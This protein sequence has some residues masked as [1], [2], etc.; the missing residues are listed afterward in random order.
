VRAYHTL[1][2]EVI[3][4]LIHYVQVPKNTPPSLLKCLNVFAKFQLGCIGVML[5][6]LSYVLV[7]SVFWLSASVQQGDLLGPLLFSLVLWTSFTLQ[8]ST[9][10]FVVSGWWY[11]YWPTVFSNH[12]VDII[13]FQDGPAF[14]LY[15]NLAKCEI[16]WSSGDS[17]CLEFL[18]AVHRVD[19]ISGSVELLGCPE[20]QTSILIVLTEVFSVCLRL[21]LYSV[22]WR[23]LKW[24]YIFC[25]V[26]SLSLAS[27]CSTRCCTA[28]FS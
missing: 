14:V 10:V 5:S 18:V 8:D 1:T 27:L 21:I 11:F 2:W 16:F 26:R 22:I 7:T 28:I 25:V 24:N 17:T 20:V 4:H 12:F 6:Q 9:A 3:F 13:F 19:I 15:L 23:I